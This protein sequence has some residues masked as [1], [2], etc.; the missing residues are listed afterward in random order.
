MESSDAFP[1]YTIVE[2]RSM[3]SPTKDVV[4][5]TPHDIYVLST[6]QPDTLIA[7]RSE[8]TSDGKA[9][10][11]RLSSAIQPLLEEIPHGV[12]VYGAPQH[13]L[14]LQQFPYDPHDAEHPPIIVS[15]I[16]AS[17][18][19]KWYRGT[20]LVPDTGPESVI[21]DGS[22]AILGVQRLYEVLEQ[23]RK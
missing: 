2:S 21:R 23:D 4:A 7:F 20:V 9:K 10:S 3:P 15:A 11:L 5:L 12:A 17:H 13:Y 16:A 6:K 14:D 22:G 8:K 19:P 1:Q 18:I